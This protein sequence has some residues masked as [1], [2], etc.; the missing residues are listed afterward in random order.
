[1]RIL[2]LDLNGA[3]KSTILYRLQVAEVNTTIPTI[4][5]NIV[6][7]PYKNLKFQIWDLGGETISRPYWRCYYSNTDAV[8]YGVDSCDQN[9]LAFP[10]QSCLPSWRKKN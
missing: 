3:G 7:V 4:G 2:I 9:E 5:F 10:N 6:T 1:M 8:I